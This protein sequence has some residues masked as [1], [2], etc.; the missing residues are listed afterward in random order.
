[1]EDAVAV[2]LVHAGVDVEARVAELSDLLGE[3]LHSLGRVTE[4]DGLVDL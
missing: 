4:D 3:Q 2:M 1:M